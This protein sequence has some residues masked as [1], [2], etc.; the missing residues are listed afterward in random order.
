MSAQG[1]EA[2]MLRILL[3]TCQ[4]AIDAFQAANNPVDQELLIDLQNM[5]ERTRR[6]LERISER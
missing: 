4:T 6:E 2:A 3:A 1:K 5:V